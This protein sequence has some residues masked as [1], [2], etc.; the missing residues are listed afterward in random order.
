MGI[1]ELTIAVWPWLL[2]MLMFLVAVTFIPGDLAVAAARSR[3]AVTKDS[4]VCSIVNTY[5]ENEHIQKTHGQSV[6]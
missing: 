6:S 2:T 4:E 5:S 3:D 1:T